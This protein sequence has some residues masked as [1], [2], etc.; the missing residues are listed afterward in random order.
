MYAIH[1]K[2]LK[3]NENGKMVLKD[4]TSGGELQQPTNLHPN[5]APPL[6]NPV[7][8]VT[9]FQN[10]SIVENSA[11]AMQQQILPPQ[12][13]NN[14]GGISSM[15]AIPVQNDEQPINGQLF[16][17]PNIVPLRAD[18]HN[19]P[20]TQPVPNDYRFFEIKVFK[21]FIF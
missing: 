6:P 21:L 7:P 19:R 12:I 10:Q 20:T 13:H 15:M 2:F 1:K 4:S 3:S 14:N 16:S 8:P 18:Q 5:L 11:A 9:F 17:P